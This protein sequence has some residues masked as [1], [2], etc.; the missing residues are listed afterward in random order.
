V[1]GTPQAGFGNNIRVGATVF[2][3]V[4]VSKYLCCRCGYIEDWIDN[5]KDIDK[6]KKYYRRKYII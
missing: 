2:S 6:V 1:P 5:H 3:A 4:L